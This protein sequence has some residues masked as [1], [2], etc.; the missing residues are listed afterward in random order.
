MNEIRNTW[1]EYKINRAYRV[2]INSNDTMYECWIRHFEYGIYLYMFGMNKTE[3]TLEDFINS[4]NSSIDEW[5][6]I[7]QER[8][9]DK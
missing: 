8:F 7:Y 3:V 2:L 5:I 4:I 1:T 9:E 6:E